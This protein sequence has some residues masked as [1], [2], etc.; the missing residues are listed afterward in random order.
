MI[1]YAEQR[2]SFVPGENDDGEEETAARD[3]D[4]AGT[5]RVRENFGGIDVSAGVDSQTKCSHMQE[6]EL[7]QGHTRL[8]LP[9]DA[10]WK[11]HKY[12][13]LG[14]SGIAGCLVSR[15]SGTFAD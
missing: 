5:K 1:S 12:G 2:C 7:E 11:T 10:R 14:L 8:V 15:N 4:S 9:T 13:G 3:A 6:Q